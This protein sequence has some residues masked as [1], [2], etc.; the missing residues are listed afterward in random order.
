MSLFFGCFAPRAPSSSPP[1]RDASAF[2]EAA[3]ADRSVGRPEGR[4]HRTDPL[5]QETRLNLRKV[6]RDG[7]LK[8]LESGVAALPEYGQRIVNVLPTYGERIVNVRS[9]Y[10]QHTANVLPTCGQTIA[11]VRRTYCQ[12]TVNTLPT[13]GERIANVR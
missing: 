9:T 11:N 10:C 6:L 7:P 4:T 13:Y 8:S 1:T 2:A 5:C 12:R 3:S